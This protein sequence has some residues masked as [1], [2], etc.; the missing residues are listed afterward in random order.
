MLEN[1]FKTK[2]Y[3]NGFIKKETIFEYV[4]E[5]EIFELVFQKTVSLTEFLKS[6]I[7]VDNNP[8]CYFRINPK[9]GKLFFVDFGSTLQTY[10]DC[11]SMVK[12]YFNL[13]NFDETINFIYDNLIVGRNLEKRIIQKKYSL[14]KN[15]E[16]TL[17]FTPRDFTQFDR[18]FWYGRYFIT[19][20]QLIEDK[21]FCTENYLLNC[22]KGTFSIIPDTPAYCYTD[23]ENGKLKI[24]KPFAKNKNRRF[25]S[26]CSNNDIGNVKNIDYNSDRLIITKAYKDS[27]VLTNE[28][29]NT[30]W[31]Q[32]EGMYPDLEMLLPICY[33]FKEIVIFYDNDEMGIK[34]SINLSNIINVYLENRAR[35]LV[36]PSSLLSKGISDPSD[37]IYKE[38]RPALLKFLFNNELL[39]Y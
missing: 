15:V 23:F 14:T 18:D 28:N 37:L 1:I 27:R 2:T 4:S 38:G 30:I 39:Q 19:K 5:K 3:V 26:N 35:P 6:P 25:V 24:Y 31:T 17:D 8:N 33:N 10:F 13:K 22:N 20:N 36:L 29:Q 12:I 32:G 9:T 21:V 16:T 34:N 7:R 11:F